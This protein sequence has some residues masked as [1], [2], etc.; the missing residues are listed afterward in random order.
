MKLRT[1]IPFFDA[2]WDRARYRY[3]PLVC[4]WL[5]HDWKR[6]GPTGHGWGICKRCF[7]RERLHYNPEVDH[8]HLDDCPGP[9]TCHYLLD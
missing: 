3:G 5:D 7:R 1:I 6:F 8:Q 9:H 2:W 4:L